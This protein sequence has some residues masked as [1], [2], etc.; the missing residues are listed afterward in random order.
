MGGEGGKKP[1]C[2]IQRHL[3][4]SQDDLHSETFL[5]TIEDRSEIENIFQ[6]YIL[7][8][9]KNLFL[10]YAQILFLQIINASHT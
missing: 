1:L 5:K 3:V 8:E 7:R 2:D 4:I 10:D 9:K 6:L